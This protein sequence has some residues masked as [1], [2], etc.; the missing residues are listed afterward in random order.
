M[1]T[2][3][4]GE[5]IVALYKEGRRSF[6][7]AN[8]YGTDLTDANLRDANLCGADL[9]GA[10]L[11]DANLRGADLRGANLTGAKLT[12]ADLYD[13]DLTGAELTGANLTGANLHRSSLR[14]H[15][16]YPSPLGYH[17]AAVW[18][19]EDWVVWAGCHRFSLS[20]A[21]AR[22]DQDGETRC[23]GQVRRW[24]AAFLDVVEAD[25]LTEMNKDD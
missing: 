7:S 8:L 25:T 24:V 22:W 16:A 14:H 6:H 15:V 1:N 20:E 23:D 17:F 11:C 3:V 2:S 10:N 21:R 9:R 18:I 19:G 13:A 12:G 5:N 4:T